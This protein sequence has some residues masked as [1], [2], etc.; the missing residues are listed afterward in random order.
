[1]KHG[2]CL[3]R[4]VIQF[5][6]FSQD[7]DCQSCHVSMSKIFLGAEYCCLLAHSNHKFGARPGVD[8]ASDRNKYQECSW[9]VKGGRRVRLTTSPPSVSRLSRK[10]GS[11]HVSQAY[12]PSRPVTGTDLP[13]FFL[14]VITSLNTRHIIGHSVCK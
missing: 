4:H 10:C 14:L 13:L 5:Q 8:S 2:T 9:G 11:L 12:G 7:M 6:K 1:L 3:K